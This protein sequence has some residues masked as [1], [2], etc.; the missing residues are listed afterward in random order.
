M[1]GG[2]NPAHRPP[3]LAETWARLRSDEDG[4]V[5]IWAAVSAAVVLGLVGLALDLSREEIT[6]SEAQAAADAA[7]LAGAAQ[8][9]LSSGSC[10]RAA[11]AAQT[12]VVNNQKFA[13]ATAGAITFSAA[14]CLSALPASDST[15]IDGSYVTTS[16]TSA[17]FLQVVTQQLTHNNFFLQLIGAPATATVQ[18]Q[19]VAGF[20]PGICEVPPLMMC[21]P[22]ETGGGGQPFDP[23]TVIGREIWAKGGAAGPGNFGLLQ[24]PI[25][26]TPSKNCIQS[27]LQANTPN[28]CFGST[29]S[30]APGQGTGPSDKGI[31]VRFGLLSSLTAPP[32]IVTTSYPD[33]SNYASSPIVGS[34]IWDCLDYWNVN[35]AGKALPPQ[36]QGSCTT[37]TNSVTRYQMYQYEQSNPPLAD[38]PLLLFAQNNRRVLYMAVVNCIQYNVQGNTGPVP[39]VGWLKTLLIKPAD[40]QDIWVEGVGMATP[41]TDPTIIK[42]DVQLYR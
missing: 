34:G 32:D 31:N 23:S 17:R 21:N 1:A 27:M 19:A 20:R 39:Y 4:S 16:D 29:V 7:A 14:N 11:S 42:D 3:A 9:D 10:A 24:N 35:H 6:H 13:G 18:A 12:L 41:A 40:Q 30:P 33:D 37:A 38:Q 15:A 5:T 8:L 36:F 28:E 22:D 25:C 26:G 2:P